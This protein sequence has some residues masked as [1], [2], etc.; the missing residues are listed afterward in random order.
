[1]TTIRK[2]SEILGEVEALA[3]FSME[4]DPNLT[5]EEARSIVW[6]EF[7]EVYDEYVASSPEP[8][9]TPVAKAVTVRTVAQ[10]CGDAVHA[11][12]DRLFLNPKDPRTVEA[13]RADL[14]LSPEG[15]K[16]IELSRSDIGSAPY[17]GFGPMQK[18][19]AR[20]E[21]WAILKHWLR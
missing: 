18:S 1:M 17:S 9:Q 10:A 15:E 8:I 2:R 11:Q 7:P 3:E 14:W 16:L 5:V 21:A 6:E 12:A 20:A 19:L 4:I 13:I